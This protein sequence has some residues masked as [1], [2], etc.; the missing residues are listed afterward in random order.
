MPNK[1]SLGTPLAP[2]NKKLPTY[3][4]DDPDLSTSLARR[5]NEIREEV[6]RNIEGSRQLKTQP[7][8]GVFSR[9]NIFKYLRKAGKLARRLVR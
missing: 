3:S 2:P 9:K 1:R 7:K 8:Y 6:Q 4:P 5:R